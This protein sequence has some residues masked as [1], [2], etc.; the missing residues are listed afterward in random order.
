MV[1][2][3]R[4]TSKAGAA[5]R[6]F[7]DRWSDSGLAGLRTLLPEWL[8]TYGKIARKPQNIEQGM[9]NDEG[10]RHVLLT[11]Y[12]RHTLF[13]ILRFFYPVPSGG[14]APMACLKPETSYR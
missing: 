14:F 10:K 13:D 4:R 11:S 1:P 5:A 12:V 3:G 8:I 6:D 7:K 2:G 9:V